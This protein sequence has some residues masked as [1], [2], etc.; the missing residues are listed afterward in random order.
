MYNTGAHDFTP[1][2]EHANEI[3]DLWTTDNL[4]NCKVSKHPANNANGS[5]HQW[6]VNIY[7]SHV[8]IH[9][10]YKRVTVNMHDP[11]TQIKQ[12]WNQNFYMVSRVEPKDDSSASK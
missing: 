4:P 5:L 7:L 12:G 9:Y 6:I 3:N 1:K 8:I 2:F 11:F 10:R